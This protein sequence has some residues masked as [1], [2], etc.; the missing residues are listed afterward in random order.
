MIL[1]RGVPEVLR[2]EARGLLVFEGPAGDLR[3]IEV[4]GRGRLAELPGAEALAG[5][6]ADVR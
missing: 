3:F 2:A 1:G 5:P 6:E 4:R